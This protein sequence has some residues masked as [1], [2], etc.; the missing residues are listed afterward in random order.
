MGERTI[1]VHPVNS[2]I[3]TRIFDLYKSGAH[4]MST[5]RKQI[6]EEFGKSISRGNVNLILKNKFYI[7]TF[8]W[9]GQTYTGT[10]PLFIDRAVF[11]EVQLVLSGH[12]RPRYSKREVAFRGLMTCANDDCMLTGD[13]Q[14]KKYV[15]YRCT[16]HRGKCGLPR[17]REEDIA[18]RLGEP[19]KRLQVPAG[20]V[21]RIVAALREDAK[22]SVGKVNSERSRLQTRLTGIRNR[23]DQAYTDKLD[24]VIPE[25][26][27]RRKR[28]DWR[29]EQS[30]VKVA[31]NALDSAQTDDRALD[32]EKIFELANKAYLLYISQNSVEQAK[33]L[34]MLVSNYS[35][36]AVSATPV[37]RKPFD[38]IS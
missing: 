13:V 33:V 36:D 20:V 24:G 32:A 11:D 23:M 3:A 38:M 9:S 30:Q 15:Y 1:E 12:N 21:S 8:E 4:T 22:E 19:L 17:F 29:V 34:R 16:G 35:V 37:W 7:G 5:L 26:F 25:E 28:N 6:K 2:L 14:K 27:W 31:L 10:H 18:L